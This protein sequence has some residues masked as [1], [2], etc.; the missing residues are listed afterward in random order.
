MA[1]PLAKAT[2]A[3][4]LSRPCNW[5]IVH[6]GQE[7]AAQTVVHVLYDCFVAAKLV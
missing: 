3:H 2:V 5:K 4:V 6:H 7:Q 1:V